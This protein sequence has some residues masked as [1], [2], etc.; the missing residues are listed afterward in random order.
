MDPAASPA[1]DDLCTRCLQPVPAGARRCP[2][3]GDPVTS[4]TSAT[5]VIALAGG[6]LMILVFLV[7]YLAVRKSEKPPQ[8]ATDDDTSVLI[9]PGGLPI[10]A[11]QPLTAAQ[12]SPVSSG[13]ASLALGAGRFL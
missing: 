1:K 4:M 6:L 10:L 9:W 3:C 8:P 13:L 2:H 7:L 12:N 11:A 5:I